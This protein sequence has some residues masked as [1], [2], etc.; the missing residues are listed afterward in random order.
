MSLDRGRGRDVCDD[1]DPYRGLYRHSRD[2]GERK[3][4]HGR[5]DRGGRGACAGCDCGYGCGSS[6]YGLGF[7]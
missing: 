6:G 5:D 1:R 2:D 7:C 3:S 4:V